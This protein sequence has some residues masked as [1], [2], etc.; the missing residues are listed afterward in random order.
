[1]FCRA[2]ILS[3]HI[4]L[5]AFAVVICVAWIDTP[6]AHLVH[7]RFESVFATS[8]IKTTGDYVYYASLIIFLLLG[9]RSTFGRPLS[10]TEQV[11]FVCCASIIIATALNL[12]LEFIFARVEPQ[13]MVGQ[14]Q[15]DLYVSARGFVFLRSAPEFRSFPSWSQATTCAFAAVLSTY[16]PKTR[17][18]LATCSLVVGCVLVLINLHF[19]GDVFAGTIVGLLAACF[20][21]AVWDWLCPLFM[22]GTND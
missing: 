5:L 1:V 8:A 16:Y 7:A 13:E 18:A 11:V 19:A 20:S 22:T 21:L 4:F 12:G 6:L 14:S 2:K 10:G 17:P 15:A 9:I 3:L